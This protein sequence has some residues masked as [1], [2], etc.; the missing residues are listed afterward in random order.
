MKME[1]PDNKLLSCDLNDVLLKLD[2][3]ISIIIKQ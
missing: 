3:N 2:N 1:E